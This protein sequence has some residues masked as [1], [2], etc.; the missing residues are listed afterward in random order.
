MNGN[1]KYQSFKPK[2]L[3]E[4]PATYLQSFNS[5]KYATRKMKTQ[6]LVDTALLITNV[7]QL[8]AVLGAAN[9]Q[10]FFVLLVK[11]LLISIL[12]QASHIYSFWAVMTEYCVLMTV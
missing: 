10:P 8:T 4:H 12:L 11:M 2:N 7:S 3:P 1:G 5:N 9:Y 6:G